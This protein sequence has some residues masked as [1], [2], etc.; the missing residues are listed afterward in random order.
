MKDEDI[1]VQQTTNFINRL[2]DKIFRKEIIF[3]RHRE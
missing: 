1:P 2:I 3:S